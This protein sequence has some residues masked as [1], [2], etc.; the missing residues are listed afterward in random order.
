MVVNSAQ[1]AGGSTRA[2]LLFPGAG[3]GRA[4]VHPHQ[5]LV[6]PPGLQHAEK[7]GARGTAFWARASARSSWMGAT[8]AA[9]ACP[10]T[11][12]LGGTLSI[13]FLYR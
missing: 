4:K 5:Q 8:T 10:K 2:R 3:I 1:S 7:T 11:G 6:F 9:I 12:R 13:R